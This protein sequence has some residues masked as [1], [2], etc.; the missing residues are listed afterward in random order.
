MKR[1]AAI[2]LLVAA[3]GALTHF[4]RS[5]DRSSLTAST[6]A[7]APAAEPHTTPEN[8]ATVQPSR[9]TQA[10]ASATAPSSAPVS[11]PA[12]VLTRIDVQAPP[13]VAPDETF[14]VMIDVQA[15]VAI[16]QLSFSVTYRKSILQLVGSTAGSFVQQGGTSVHFEDV[17]E[18]SLLVRVESGVIAGAGTIAALEFHAIGRGVSPIAV[19]TVTYVEDGRAERPVNRP[20]AYEGSITVE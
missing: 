9:A 7:I 15:P 3:F 12:A 10:P 20:T 13:T 2:A 11:A 4:W 5:A 17:S 14:L 16:R 1:L 18:G 8:P 6:T 19:E